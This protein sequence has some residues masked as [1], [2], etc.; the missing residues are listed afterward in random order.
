MSDETRPHILFITTDQQRS[1][2]IGVYGS[3]Q[4]KTPNI[5]ALAQRGTLFAR[6]YSQN[7]VCIPARTSMATGRYIH[8]HTVADKT[9]NR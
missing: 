2:T 8:Q 5:D 4:V 6:A 1:D 7:T 9:L 3:R